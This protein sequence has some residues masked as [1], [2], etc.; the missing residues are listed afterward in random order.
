MQLEKKVSRRKI[1]SFVCRNGRITKA[2]KYALDYYWPLMGILYSP[3]YLNIDKLFGNIKK[4][5]I[6]LNIGFGMGFELIQQA[7]KYPN[8]YFIGIEVYLPGIGNCLNLARKIGLLNIRII[9][10]DA[11]EVI[12]TMIPHNSISILQLYFPDPWQKRCHNKRRIV[13]TNFAHLVLHRLK[14][15]GIFHIATDCINYAKHILNVMNAISGYKN[16]SLTKDYINRPKT[17]PLTKFEQIGYKKG[18]QIIDLMF[19]KIINK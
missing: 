6:V 1:R 2:Q 15:N 3:Q 12:E 14:L 13:Q 4:K 10:H 17:R 8:K 18:N 5:Q 11:V 16:L 9:C 7:L 19:K